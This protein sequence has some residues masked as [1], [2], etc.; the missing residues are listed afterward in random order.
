MLT[1]IKGAIFDVDGTLLD[2]MPMWENIAV[3]YLKKRGITPKPTMKDDMLGLGSH[4]LLTYFHNEY[5]LRETVEEIQFGMYE[6]LEEFYYFKAPVKKGVVPV[7]NILRD[8]NIKMCIATATDKWLVEPAL[9][10]LDIIDYF[11]YVFTCGEESTNKSS[12]DIFIRA[13]EYLGTDIHDTLVVEDAL[14]AMKSAKG[15]GFQVAAVYD[16]SAHDKQDEIKGIC[17]YYFI[18]MDEMLELIT[19]SRADGILMPTV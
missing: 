3:E 1:K 13:A 19:P 4:K 18:S 17:D 15:A 9:K 14:Y 16:Q 11:E 6:L 7:L 2:S 10:R 12:P 8:N 5:G